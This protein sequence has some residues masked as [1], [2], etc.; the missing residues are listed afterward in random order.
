MSIAIQCIGSVPEELRDSVARWWERA[1]A[2][3]G[4]LEAYQALAEAHRAQ[5]PR[6]VAASEFVA[7][8]LIQDPQSLAWFSRHD[9]GTSSLANADYERQAATAA[10]VEQAQFTLR[11][12]RRR[13][14]LRI[15]WRDIAGIAPVIDTLQD[16][17]DLADAA[18][19]AAAAAA[20]LQ[21]LPIFGP[22][23]SPNESSSP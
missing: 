10:T 4:F 8:A 3:Q 5:L 2:Q 23:H 7:S 22:P 17:S 16:V 15:A 9:S 1:R 20:R 14:M 6:V 21:L 11:E 19:R 18:I 12:W 13:A